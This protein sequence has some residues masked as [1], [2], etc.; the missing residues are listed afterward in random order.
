M[1]TMPDFPR[2]LRAIGPLRLLIL[3]GVAAGVVA[4]FA[5]MFNTV[6][7]PDYALL[8][9]DLDASDSAQIVS[10]LES[11]AIPYKLSQDGDTI[12]V[13]RDDAAKLRLQ[14]A[15]QGL[16]SGGSMG[17]E[18][19]DESDGFG[20]TRFTQNVNLVR[21]LEG[22]LARTIRSLDPVKNAR[23]HL[24]LPKRE[25]FQRDQRQPSASIFLQM[26]GSRRL[27][28]GQVSA[29]QN[30]VASAVPELSPERISIVD[31]R[32]TLLSE[33]SGD[34][35]AVTGARAD[36]RRQ[37]LEQDLTRTIESL[38]EKTVGPGNVRAQVFADMDFDRINSSEEIYDPDGQVVR[39]TQTVE[40][41]ASDK[42]GQAE[43][44]VGVLPNLP[45]ADQGGTDQRSRS[46]AES[47]S[48][49]TV[50]YEISKKVVNHVRETG[51]IRRLSVAV[52]V[53]GRYTE[54]G[55]GQIVYT[56]RPEN[57]L[58]LIAKLVR[59]AIGF[60]QARGDSVEVINMRFAQ[61]DVVEEE[62]P[63]DVL[64]LGK[65]D[66]LKL[67]E[68][69]GVV[70][71]GLL[72]ILLVVRPLIRRTLDVAPGGASTR[73]I[74]A[75]QAAPALPA[76]EGTT[77]LAALSGDNG[78]AGEAMINLSQVEGKVKASSV[79]QIGEFVTNHPD[80]SLSIIR[81]WLHADT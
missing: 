61:P 63:F 75:N 71:L 52:L 58:A 69:L 38:V 49:E 55:G 60:D 35:A 23:V 21:A 72:V 39:S 37:T 50:N 28:A 65:H 79:N 68:L 73:S 42:E 45:D 16:P 64:G 76:P 18:I 44:P 15:E 43:Q 6:S 80:E 33:G 13:P 53:D 9:G 78:A 51:N 54:D 25:L 47:R 3:A 14:L 4:A 26:K 62:Q 81:T 77:A 7:E 70:I 32:G 12:L 10:E 17:Y 27:T 36:E 22:E 31:G 19:F 66:I 46:S 59:G 30:L 74:P 1:G 56:P 8:F 20:A 48:E 5:W 57:E 40:Q 24:V 67:A 29:V 2:L 41:S 11:R 34:P